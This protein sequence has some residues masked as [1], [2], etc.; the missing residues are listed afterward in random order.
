MSTREFIIT[1]LLILIG[2]GLVTVSAS[3][4]I[5]VCIMADLEPELRG[6]MLG[7]FDAV[8]IPVYVLAFGGGAGSFLFALVRILGHKKPRRR[9]DR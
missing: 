3:V 4:L 6:A 7:R 9:G 1:L 8:P 2:A 5:A